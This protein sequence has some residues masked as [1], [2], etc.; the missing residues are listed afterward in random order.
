MRY[1]PEC[2]GPLIWNSKLKQYVCESCG[3]MFTRKELDDYKRKIFKEGEIKEQDYKKEYEK[4]WISSHK[5]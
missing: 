2:G 3:A 1:C 4:W 5:S